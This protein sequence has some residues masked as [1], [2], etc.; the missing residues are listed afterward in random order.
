MKQRITFQL[1]GLLYSQ[2]KDKIKKLFK[3]YGLKFNQGACLSNNL[4]LWQGD[5]QQVEGKFFKDDDGQ[6]LRS[7]LI[8]TC[9]EETDL[10]AEMDALISSLGGSL[11]EANKEEMKEEEVKEEEA[12]RDDFEKKWRHRLLNEERNARSK[13]FKHCPILLPMVK[14]YLTEREKPFKEHDA[15]KLVSKIHDMIDKEKGVK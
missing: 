9:E 6:T 1:P 8:W 12:E 11:E 15:N 10:M 5:K 14:Q 7:E 13:G 2:N 4:F 3:K